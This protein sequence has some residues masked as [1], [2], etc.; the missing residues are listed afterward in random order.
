MN[1]NALH[2]QWKM[3]RIKTNLMQIKDNS[4]ILIFVDNCNIMGMWELIK[5]FYKKSLVDSLQNNNTKY[6]KYDV[7]N[8]KLDF[9]SP[10]TLSFMK[11]DKQKFQQVISSSNIGL[12][13]A[14]IVYISFFFHNTKNLVILHPFLIIHICINFLS[15]W[16][17]CIKLDTHEN[18]LTWR[19]YNPFIN[20][21]LHVVMNILMYAGAV[22]VFHSE[23]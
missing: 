13:N 6:K 14:S 3:H 18:A 20:D 16:K 12:S 17:I 11:I 22:F 7:C 4:R 5:L 19:I 9:G 2:D 1:V 23:L 15:T 21:K 8:S 10:K